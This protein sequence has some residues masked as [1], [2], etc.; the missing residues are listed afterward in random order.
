[1]LENGLVGRD[2]YLF[3]SFFNQLGIHKNILNVNQREGGVDNYWESRP[4]QHLDDPHDW[5]PLHKTQIYDFTWSFKHV[6][7]CVKLRLPLRTKNHL[8]NISDWAEWNL[9]KT[10]VKEATSGTVVR[11]PMTDYS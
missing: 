10:L 6:A 11:A 2:H 9:L 1:V 7:R 5:Q 8:R 4:S 3:L